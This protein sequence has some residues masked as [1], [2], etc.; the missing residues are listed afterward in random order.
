[1]TPRAHSGQS[2]QRQSGATA[3][4][5]AIVSAIFF[6]ILLGVVEMGRMLYYW[7]SAVEAT[8]LGARL[9]VVCDM[10]DADIKSRMIGMWPELTAARIQIDY[11]NP[12]AA[13][14]TCTVDTCKRVSVKIVSFNETPL[15]PFIAM[16][17]AVPEFVTTLPRE[18]MS[19]ANNAVCS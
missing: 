5:L 19:S 2:R 11:L 6:T 13:V 9:A 8:R 15:I 17:L 7:N 18:S 10:N 1:M 16:T 14:N 3:V 12:P 4:E